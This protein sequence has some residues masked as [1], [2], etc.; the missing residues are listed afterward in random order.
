MKYFY[1][2]VCVLMSGCNS[3]LNTK[4]PFVNDISSLP[5]ATLKH[6]QSDSNNM[7]IQKVDSV[8]T[9]GTL[10]GDD[11]VYTG[12]VYVQPGSRVVSVSCFD[13]SGSESGIA[14]YN[15][16]NISLNVDAKKVYQFSCKTA[17]GFRAEYNVVDS[18]GG[19]VN[20]ELKSLE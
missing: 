18:A 1:L 6:Y 14:A 10:L 11:L 16:V 3:T 9:G 17:V 4:A 20:F 12:D 15:K 5:Y 8:P 13:R 19:E 7:W 2:A